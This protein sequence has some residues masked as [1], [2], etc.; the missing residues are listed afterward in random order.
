MS[1]SPLFN[2]GP[3]SVDPD[4]NALVGLP[5]LLLLLEDPSIVKL[6]FILIIPSGGADERACVD[7]RVME[8]L[9]VGEVLDVVPEDAAL[10][11]GTGVEEEEVEVSVEVEEEGVEVGA[12]EDVVVDW[13]EMEAVAEGIGVKREERGRTAWLGTTRN[14]GNLSPACT[15]ALGKRDVLG[16]RVE[17]E[18]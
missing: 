10:D 2:R 17:L 1:L 18:L 5:K 6:F 14:P 12:V 3:S 8:V 13:V 7:G 16:E 15:V 11:A 4:K 9:E